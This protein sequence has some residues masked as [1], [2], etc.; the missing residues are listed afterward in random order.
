MEFSDYAVVLQTAIGGQ[1]VALGW[2]SAISRM[3]RDGTLVPAAPYL[4]ETGRSFNLIA[5]RG[6]PVRSIVL[7][8]RDW[9]IEE[10][11][12]D[13]KALAPM[14]SVARKNVAVAE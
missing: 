9:L 4:L 7:G 13:L 12:A 5:P 8:I 14:L 3:L 2:I 11:L 1:G 10:M 6:R